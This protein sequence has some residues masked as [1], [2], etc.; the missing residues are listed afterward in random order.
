MISDLVKLKH[1]HIIKWSLPLGDTSKICMLALSIE[2]C[3]LNSVVSLSKCMQHQ[4]WKEQKLGTFHK[5]IFLTVSH[6]KC[7]DLTTPHKTTKIKI[8]IIF[9]VIALYLKPKSTFFPSQLLWN[10]P[11]SIKVRLTIVQRGLFSLFVYKLL[12][13]CSGGHLPYETTWL[14]RLDKAGWLLWTDGGEKIT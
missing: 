10:Y 13:V 12:I 5:S 6:H 3:A 7:P 14:N 1:F 9:T 8:S 2:H 11:Y 4:V